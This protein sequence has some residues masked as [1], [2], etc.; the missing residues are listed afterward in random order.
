MTS[1][2]PAAIDGLLALLRARPSLERV[3]IV[4]GYPRFDIVDTAFIAIG[5]KPEPVAEGAQSSAALGARKREERYTL[6]VYCSASLGGDDQKA[7]RDQA[8]SLMAEVEDAVRQDVTLG[9]AV[10]VAEVAGSISL[11][12]TDHDTAAFGVFAEVSF[13]VAVQARI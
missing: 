6:R 12:Q 9:G 1:T 8:F 2:M 11:S 7:A 3:Q 4:D 10:R 13:D 5:G